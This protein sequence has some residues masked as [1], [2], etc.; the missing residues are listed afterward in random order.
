MQ[1]KEG[2]KSMKGGGLPFV[3]VIT[4]GNPGQC[5]VGPAGADTCEGWVS[6]R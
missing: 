1:E 4:A 3:G 5:Q 2:T 6:G